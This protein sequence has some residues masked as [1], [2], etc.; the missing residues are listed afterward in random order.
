MKKSLTQK[1]QGNMSYDDIDAQLYGMDDDD[2]QYDEDDFYAQDES[3]DLTTQMSKLFGKNKSKSSKNEESSQDDDSEASQS[4]RYDNDDDNEDEE[5]SPRPKKTSSKKP[6]PKK[7][8][9]K[10]RQQSESEEDDDDDEDNMITSPPSK[11]TSSKKP[12]PKKRQQSE[13]EE[14]DDEEDEI[15]AKKSKKLKPYETYDVNKEGRYLDSYLTGNIG[16]LYDQIGSSGLLTY[17]ERNQKGTMA[18]SLVLMAA[19]SKNPVAY[20]SAFRNFSA[21]RFNADWL[22]KICAALLK[23][24]ESAY[25]KYGAKF[26]HCTVRYSD[27]HRVPN[28]YSISKSALV[29]ISPE[30]IIFNLFNDKMKTEEKKKRDVDATTF[31]WYPPASTKSKGKGIDHNKLA[32]PGSMVFTKDELKFKTKPIQ[33]KE[34]RYCIIQFH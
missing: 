32:Y 29:L 31:D 12:P 16:R 24:V 11:K 15:P 5:E 2:S 17:A 8:S 4:S 34:H 9:S 13:S 7:T 33:G 18:Q 28:P 25:G 10:K 30:P 19:Y 27:G 21:K 23:V 20:K 26:E 1:T 22:G 6:P 14:D 3:E